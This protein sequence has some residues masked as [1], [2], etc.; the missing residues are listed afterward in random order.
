MAD[1]L[2]Q[3]VDA[4]GEILEGLLRRAEDVKETHTVEPPLNKADLA[5]ILEGLESSLF[6]SADSIE[7]RKRV[8]AVIETVVRD[9]FNNL[10]VSISLLRTYEPTLTCQ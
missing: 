9:K 6:A 5:D 2:V 7:Q 1:Q 3:G 10:L 4:F 8:H